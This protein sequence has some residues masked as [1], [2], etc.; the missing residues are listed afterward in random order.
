[1]DRKTVLSILNL[2]DDPDN[3]VY[4]EIR[5]I[6]VENFGDFSGE[7]TKRIYSGEC[8]EIE[9]HRIVEAAQLSISRIFLNEFK[10][11]TAKLTPEPSLL[12]GT[13]MIEKI[14]DNTFNAYDFM[15][16]MRNLARKVWLHLDDNTG[17]ETLV[18]IRDVFKKENII[19]DDNG[20]SML[21]GIFSRETKTIR[22]SL[23]HL[24]FLIVCQEIGINIRPIITPY[25]KG[26]K[27]EIGYVNME[28]AKVSNIPSKHG[29]IFPIDE[30]LQV[31]RSSIILLGKPLPYYKYL[32][33]WQTDRCTEMQVDPN[34][35]P[36]YYSVIM[37][38][39]N[40]VLVRNI[41]Y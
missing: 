20:S 4:D 37:E 29:A 28:L 40:E 39:I 13:V 19:A 9:K 8:G 10:N 41:K 5:D 1:M 22:K 18:I 38:K 30:N 7:F 2:L 16:E 31:K 32:R 27:L 23:F 6:I 26:K 25:D 12:T 21:N 17:Y 24:L 14:T 3:K 33:H 34:K 11:Y 15:V 35:Y 36:R